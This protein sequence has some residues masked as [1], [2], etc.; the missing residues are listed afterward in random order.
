MTICH[1]NHLFPE[2]LRISLMFLLTFAVLGLNSP[3]HS[4]CS[5][6]AIIAF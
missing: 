4:L 2:E 6:S 3:R 1:E 5:E